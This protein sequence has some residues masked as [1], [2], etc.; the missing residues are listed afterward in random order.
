MIPTVRTAAAEMSNT[1]CRVGHG[2]DRRFYSQCCRKPFGVFFF[3][4]LKRVGR[5][6]N[7]SIMKIK[8]EIQ[9]VGALRTVCLRY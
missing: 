5:L 6:P 2:K 1:T 3:F 4:F 9:E 7:R 8:Q